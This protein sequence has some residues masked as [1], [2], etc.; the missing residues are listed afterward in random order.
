V[1]QPGRLARDLLA[2]NRELAVDLL[3]AWQAL[4]AT[5]EQVVRRYDLSPFKVR[6][7]LSDFSSGRASSLGAEQ[8]HRLL[9]RRLELAAGEYG[10]G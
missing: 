1:A 5:P 2:E 7:Y 10:E 3:A 9:C 8:F 4:P 6:D